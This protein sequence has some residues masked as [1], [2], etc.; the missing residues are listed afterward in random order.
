MMMAPV[1]PV[2]AVMT[3]ATRVIVATA[4][5]ATLVTRGGVQAD[6]TTMPTT[7][8]PLSV[9][10]AATPPL[11]LLLPADAPAP[12]IATTTGVVAAAFPHA[13][14]AT[15]MTMARTTDEAD[16]IRA[17][18]AIRAMAVTRAW[19]ILSAVVVVSPR[20]VQCR[21]A[22]TPMVGMR[23]HAAAAAEI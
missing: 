21:V 2:R 13:A 7:A 15:T 14:D 3:V 11:A 20:H 8:N 12:M 22:T 1:A 9:R 17:I 16:A 19:I 23:R 4:M 5:T 10:H 18:R 6:A